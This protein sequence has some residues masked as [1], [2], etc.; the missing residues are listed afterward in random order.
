MTLDLNKTGGVSPPTSGEII[1]V[2]S[3]LFGAVFP[4]KIL[5]VTDLAALISQRPEVCPDAI[6]H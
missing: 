1:L 3:A 5:D 6:R 2:S 4:Q